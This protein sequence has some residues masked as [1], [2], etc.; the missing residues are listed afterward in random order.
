MDKKITRI[1]I[2]NLLLLFL[3]G[4]S[5]LYANRNDT[6]YIKGYYFVIYNR[7]DIEESYVQQKRAAEGK[8][9]THMIDFDKSYFFL[10]IQIGNTPM[11]EFDTI[12]NERNR[13]SRN[14]SVFIFPPEYDISVM[15]ELNLVTDNAIYVP[16][17]LSKAI[18]MSPYYIIDDNKQ[19]M[20][21]SVYIE[22]YAIHKDIQEVEKKWRSYL[23]GARLKDG[24]VHQD[25]YIIDQIINYTPYIENK[26]FKKW[27]PYTR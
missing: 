2:C 12:E 5:L 20:Y 9:S 22:G 23:L 19:Y 15:K 17:I 8:S 26:R 21:K 18:N 25:I 10:P 4:N 11:C 3:G 14:D 27:L 7:A 24:N 6:C 16:L 1:I 13:F